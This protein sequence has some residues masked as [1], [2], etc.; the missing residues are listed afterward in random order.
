[1]WPYHWTNKLFRLILLNKEPNLD[2]PNPRRTSAANHIH[3]CL[4]ST[5]ALANEHRDQW[6]NCFEVCI[7]PQAEITAGHLPERERCVSS[8]SYSCEETVVETVDSFKFPKLFKKPQEGIVVLAP[9][10]SVTF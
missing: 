5:A 3:P 4:L 6:A 1:M 2:I 7:A 9:I 10:Y 8:N